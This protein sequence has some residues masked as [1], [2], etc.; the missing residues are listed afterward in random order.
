ML[1]TTIILYIIVG[2]FLLLLIQALIRLLRVRAWINTKTKGIMTEVGY[3]EYNKGEASE[4]FVSGGSRTPI[5][6]VIIGESRD[7]KGYVEILS[8]SYE[9]SSGKPSYRSCGYISPDGYIY[10][11]IGKGK[12][13]EK[14]GYTARPSNPNVPTSVGERTWKTLW[15]KC[16]LNAYLGLPI[17]TENTEKKNEKDSVEKDKKKVEKIMGIAADVGFTEDT[18]NTETTESAEKVP[19]PAQHET[20]E[21]TFTAEDM[22][23]LE[24]TTSS[25]TGNVFAEE[26]VPEV[27][28][29]ANMSGEAETTEKGSSTEETNVPKTEDAPEKTKIPMLPVVEDWTEE[30]KKELDTIKTQSASILKK[31]LANMVLVEGGQFIMGADQETD[32]KTTEDNKGTI[33]SNESPKHNVTV[34]DYY[35]NKFPVTQAE[36]KTV[37]GKNPS[38]CQDNDNYPVAPI[39]WK[40][41][42][43]F[44]KRLSYLADTTFMLPT[45]AQWEY[46]ARGGKKSHGYIFSGS[47]EFAEVGHKDY[48]HEVG[49]KKP[50]ELGLYDMSGLVREWCS[51]LWGHY[52]AD[53]QTNPTGPSEDS[54]LIVKDTEGNFMRAVRSPAG[55]E[56][57][58]NRKGENPELIKD[59][60]SYGLRIVCMNIPEK[61]KK[62]E[63]TENEIS[64]IAPISPNRKGNKSSI[65]SGANKPFAICSHWGFHCSKKDLLSPESRA[66]AFALFFHLYNKNNYSEYYK[67][68]PYGWRDTAL[69]SSFVYSLLYLLAYILVTYV[70]K[71]SFVGNN[72]V[73]A[74]E[75]IAFYF[76]LWAL[77]RQLKIYSIESL[78]SIQP[79]LDLFNKS[80]GHKW[81]DYT[82]IF[83]GLLSFAFIFDYY[84]NLDW[85]PLIIAI[86]IGIIVNMLSKPAHS[87]WIIRNSFVNNDDIDE[88]ED[89]EPKNPKGDIARTYDWDLDSKVSDKKLHGN[90]T[91]YFTASTITDLKQI[92]PFYDQLKEKDDKEYIMDMFHYMKEHKSLLA[93]L[94]YIVYNIRE[95]CEKHSLHELDR[96]QFILDFVQEPNIKFCMNKDCDA[97]N[98]FED[99]IRF[100]DETLYYKE[101]DSNS[102][103][104]LAAMLFHLMRHNVLYLHSRTQEHAAIGVEVNPIWLQKL[105]S[106]QTIDE[107]TLDYNGKKYIFCETTG[108]TLKIIDVMEGMKF[109]DFEERVELPIQEDDIDDVNMSDTQETRLYNWDLDSIMGNKLHG[110]FTLEFNRNDIINLREQNPF[111]TYGEDGFSYEQNIRRIFDII[112]SQDNSCIENV[113]AITR[114]IKESCT[115]AKLPELDLVQFALD[116]AQAPNINYCIDENSE[117]INFAKEYMRF[118][119]EVL[120]DKEGDCDCKS[121][122]TAALFHELGYNVIIMLS[123]KLGHAAIGI[124]LKEEWLNEIKADNPERVVREYN[125]KRYLYCETTGDGYKIGHIK[126]NESI[127]DFETIVEIPV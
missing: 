108:D 34:S 1:D 95:L 47:N 111:R 124:E 70:W 68:R 82:L 85:I 58:T 64:P 102:K 52:T 79:K 56:T 69:L 91:L 98:R 72:G 15:L 118:P 117:S 123:Q 19:S 127:Q 43:T 50:N 114:Y 78:N 13:P 96:I 9:E 61:Y 65:V 77:V 59:F 27:T 121:S 66:C 2:W 30:E 101:G 20:S 29:E 92:N 62:H 110:S 6:H 44:L 33:E 107:M 11:K 119:D 7:E 22:V 28:E 3:L 63:D 45:E 83:L 35:I 86:I 41:C 26:D 16:T 88:D 94:R 18:G 76:L 105:G 55:N 87:P 84:Q 32:E 81:F 54:P 116:F 71:E 100:P 23:T 14:I 74:I 37:M 39:T 60:K 10:K 104:L 12:R 38:E 57:V 25:E 53:D 80:L 115:Q 5:G 112:T 42:Q 90:L 109:E 49:T 120:Y 106:K 17:A 97:I 40:D 99:Y 103:A 36:W 122:L 24:E 113:R 93:R 67:D 21:E 73:I 46:A 48:R 31:M 89:E 8:S 75:F 51:D 125:G 4:V 126:D